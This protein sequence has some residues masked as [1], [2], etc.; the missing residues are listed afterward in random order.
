MP[1]SSVNGDESC[2]WFGENRR[3]ESPPVMF[4]RG[5]AG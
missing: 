1:D 5:A 4:E 3:E 2:R